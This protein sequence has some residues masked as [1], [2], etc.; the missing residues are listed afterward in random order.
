M[1]EIADTGPDGATE[2][3]DAAGAMTTYP[4][5]YL[6]GV[7]KAGTTA[8][9]TYLLEHPN[10]FLPVPVGGSI[11]QKEPMYFATDLRE[12]QDFTDRDAYLGLYADAGDEH[13]PTL[14][15]GDSDQLEVGDL[16]LAIGDPFGVGQT[17]T[18]GI[19]S[20]L[21]RTEVGISDYQFF[22]Q[23]DAAINP[24]NSGGALIDMDGRVI[25][26]NSQIQ[27]GGSSGNVGIGFAV[28]INT[29][30]DVVEQIKTGGKVQHAY[31]GISGG[32]VT[33]SLAEALD[34]PVKEGVLVNEVVKGGPADDAGIKG[35]DDTAS[36]EGA[37][38]R[39]GGDIIVKVDGDAVTAMDEVI[40]AVN[41]AQPGDKMVLTVR[42]GDSTKTISVELGV[43]PASAEDTQSGPVGPPSR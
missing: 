13:L 42:R 23:T 7:P 28:P 15:M 36:I 1:L 4:N 9:Y 14:P 26:I 31:L 16:V 29:A 35:G 18:N 8:L 25:G 19:V 21:S 39:V 10:I 17:V 11:K 37:N 27:T 2:P 33:P 20:A 34:L 6:A 38:L 41:A 3:G 5:F 43:R 22:I 40:E 24:G 12:D 32:S 30:K